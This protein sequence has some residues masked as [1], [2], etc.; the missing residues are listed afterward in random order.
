MKE[1][2][3]VQEKF[4]YG[5]S[6]Y[7]EE[8]LIEILSNLVLHVENEV[9]EFKLASSNFDNH[10]L[11][12]YFSAISNEA[13]LRNKKYGWLIFGVHDTTHEFLGTNYKDSPKALEKL[14]HDVAKDTTGAI[15]FMDIFVVRPL[16]SST[17]KPVRII[18]FQ[19]PAAVTAIPTGWKNRYYGRD[20]ESL[21]DLS[22][23][24]IDRIRGERRIDWTRE[25]L[26]GAS[27]TN[28]DKEAITI[29][30]SNY[31]DRLS[32]AANPKAITELDKMD[33]YQF[34]SKVKLIRNGQITKAA[35]VLLGNS[36]YSDFFEIPPQIMWRLYD[37]KGNTIDHEIFDIPFLCAVDSV[38]KKIRNLTYRY[39]P[40]QLSLFPTETQQYDSWLLRELINNCIA[41]QD[42]TAGRRIYIDEFEDHI[43]ISNAGHFLP[44]DIKPVLEPAY[45]PPYYRNPLLAQAMVDFKMIDTA[46]MGIRRVYS[47]Q[48]EKLFPMPDY[49]LT[50]QNYV[51]VT[52]YG[53]VLNEN[54]TKILFEHPDMD[55]DTVY[56]LD[57]VQ[58]G[59]SISRAE[60]TKLRKLGLVEGKIP[61][62]FISATVAEALDQKAQYIKNKGF[63]DQFYKKMIV[64]YLT[65]WGKGNKTDFEKLLFDKLP[66][67]LTLK[68]KNNKLRNLLS[69]LRIQ[70]VIQ[71]DSKNHQTSYWILTQSKDD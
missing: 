2:S 37:H 70:G 35:F 71:T 29:A 20:G 55:L 5:I 62:L 67:S 65:K 60:V 11:G 17:G 10:K 7:S 16:S 68:Q 58:K 28:L 33:D 66:D 36:D 18:M 53:K 47:I 23:E 51:C 34:L 63:N 3:C 22:Q 12:Q 64:D 54:Y 19:I 46:S 38:Y 52:V 24:K 26:E 9:V 6:G 1:V 40:N 44:G 13:N 45:A 43:V 49:D 27:L 21:V 61:K 59:K 8:N 30:R 25:I 56:L 4:D 57:K 14:K 42:Y 31:R 32:N 15:T 39:M 41:H 69:A 48:K 50:K